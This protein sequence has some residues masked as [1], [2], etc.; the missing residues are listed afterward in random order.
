VDTELLSQFAGGTGKIAALTQGV[1]LKRIGTPEEIAQVIVFLASDKANF[2][3]GEIVHI[4]G[5]KT[6]L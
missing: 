1:P 5:G 2:V 6:A 4:N 3:T